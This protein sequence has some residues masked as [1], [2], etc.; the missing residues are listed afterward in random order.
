[1]T[2]F[3]LKD[4][5]EVK[6]G[7]TIRVESKTETPFGEG[8]TSIDVVVTENNIPT[9]VKNGILIVKNDTEATIKSYIRKVAKTHNMD[10]LEASAFLGVMIDYDKFLVLYLLLKAASEKAMC[11][12]NG[13]TC[14]IIQLHNGKMSTI[15][16]ENI[17]SHVLVFPTHEEANNAIEVLSSLYKE[18]YGDK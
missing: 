4:D 5:Q 15:K 16:K 1:M 6:I 10:Y 11:G 13:D 17:L 3:Y 12:Y 9:L 18:V 14:V 7:S 2:R 8:I